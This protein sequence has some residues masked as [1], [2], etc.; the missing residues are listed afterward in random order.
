MNFNE[1]LPLILVRE[2]T[3]AVDYL[4]LETLIAGDKPVVLATDGYTVSFMFNGA[5][6]GSGFPHSAL[7]IPLNITCREF[8]A[9]LES[10][11]APEPECKIFVDLL[12]EG[13]EISVTIQSHYLTVHDAKYKTT[14]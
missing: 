8:Y 3:I 11:A 5:S 7:Q 9:K 4:Y 6:C 14:D 13:D 2:V 1:P 12:L 10:K